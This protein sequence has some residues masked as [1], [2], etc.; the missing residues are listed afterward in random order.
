MSAYLKHVQPPRTDAPIFTRKYRANAG[1]PFI[2]PTAECIRKGVWL[3]RRQQEKPPRIAP[4]TGQPRTFKHSP[5]A[6]CIFTV[7]PGT[8]RYRRARSVSVPS[9]PQLHTPTERLPEN[10]SSARQPRTFKYFASAHCILVLAP[11]KL[12]P[13]RARSVSVPSQTRLH[14]PTEHLPENS[15]SARRTDR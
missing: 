6:H 11:G 8:L 1:D 14:T 7:A 13:H 2:A 10:S 15:P 4:T 5:S 3:S 9:Q 12:P